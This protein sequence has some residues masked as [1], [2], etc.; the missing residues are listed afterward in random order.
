MIANAALEMYLLIDNFNKMIY[1]K[2]KQI[3]NIVKHILHYAS[4]FVWNFHEPKPTLLFSKNIP[5]EE[6]S[7]INLQFPKILIKSEASKNLSKLLY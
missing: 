7:S 5:W 6:H 2:L 1:Q 3:S 4:Q